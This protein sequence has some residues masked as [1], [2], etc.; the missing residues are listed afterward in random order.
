MHPRLQRQRRHHLRHHRLVA[1]FSDAHLDLVGEI[2]AFDLFQKTVD[3]VL[4]RLLA[5]GDDVDA[6]I[7]LQFDRQN[8]RVALGTGQLLTLGL[9]GRPQRVRLGQ[10]F[11]F[12]QGACNG[13]WKQH[14]NLPDSV[15]W[16]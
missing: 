11:R 7:F 14:E 10:P 16:L 6:G 9:P 8:R 5:L 1:V 4:P 2:D 12:W 3:E 15:V 13:G